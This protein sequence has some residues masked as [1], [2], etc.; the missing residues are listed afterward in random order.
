VRKAYERSDAVPELRVEL[1]K[2]KAMEWILR[3]VEVV[4]GEGRSIERSLLLPDDELSD[5]AAEATPPA[6]GGGTDDEDIEDD[7]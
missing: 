6:A 1:S 4:D 2:R 3:T 7:E 5:V